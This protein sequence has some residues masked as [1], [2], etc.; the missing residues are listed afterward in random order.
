MGEKRHVKFRHVIEKRTVQISI[1]VFIT[2]FAL[3]Y[4]IWNTAQMRGKLENTTQNY[5]EEITA[6]MRDF[7]NFGINSKMIELVNVADSLSQA[8]E[9][10]EETLKD[11]LTRKADILEFD[12]LILLGSQDSCTTL[13]SGDETELELPKIEEIFRDEIFFDGQSHM[14]FLD[15]QS[16]YYSAPVYMQESSVHVLVGIRVKSTMQNALASK[17]LQ[18][19][20]LSCIVDNKSSVLL[21]PTNVKPFMELDDIFQNDPNGETS[22]EI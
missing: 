1:L 3:L 13:V 12:A 2:A 6:Q 10:D 21:S 20:T 7:V 16:L 15:G 11:F 19:S 9:Y 8:Y 22:K 5:G 14:G 4:A 17:V 18:N